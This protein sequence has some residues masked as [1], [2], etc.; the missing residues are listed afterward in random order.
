MTVA[1]DE[2]R[3]AQVVA[4]LL[5]NAAK[6]TSAPC[7]RTARAR[8]GNAHRPDVIVLDIGMPGA[9]GDEVARWTRGST[10]AS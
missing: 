1:G 9:N 5:V 2:V 4:K 6:F 7:G 8:P 10:Y 3:L